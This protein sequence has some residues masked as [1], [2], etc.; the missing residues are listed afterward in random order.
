MMMMMD[1]DSSQMQQLVLAVFTGW[2]WWLSHSARQA[3]R[4]DNKV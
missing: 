2:I 3:W 1:V 4:L